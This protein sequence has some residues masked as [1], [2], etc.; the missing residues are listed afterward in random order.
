MMDMEKLIADAGR[1][2][3]ALW[4]LNLALLRGIPFN[5]PHNLKVV[6]ISEH[7]TVVRYPYK[8]SNLNHLKGLHACGLATAA[9]YAAGLTLLTKLGA[10][11]YRFILE[12]LEMKYHYQGKKDAIAKCR[13]DEEKIRKEV[14]EP[15]TT[16]DATYIRCT[17]EVYDTDGNHL[18]TGISTWQIKSWEK[19]KTQVGSGMTH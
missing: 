12:S 2:K 16:D 1:S 15:L 10:S 4:K 17:A 19:V 13:V 9:E 7:E 18:S 5:K 14:I 8:R 11:K 6:G 3:F